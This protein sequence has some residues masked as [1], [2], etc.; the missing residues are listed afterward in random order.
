MTTIKNKTEGSA[1]ECIKSH[2]S[3]RKI[4]RNILKKVSAKLPHQL[5]AELKR[6][7]YGRQIKKGSFL[8]DEPEY[9]LL[10]GLIRSGDWVIDIGANIGHYT[11]R[12]SELVGATGRVIAFEPVPTTFSLLSANSQMF[13]HPNVTL[14]NTAVSNSLDVVGI[15][16]PQHFTGVSNYYRAHLSPAADSALSVL[17]MSLDSLYLDQPIACVKIDVEGHEAT[18]LAGMKKLIERSHPI[19]IVETGSD[20]VIND[21]TAMGYVA[22]RLNGSPNVLF[23]PSA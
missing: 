22:E 19:L 18:V 9:E 4:Y 23:R 1:Q 6:I 21:V 12:F 11:K 5:Q 2:E 8:T 15:S 16:I 20:K 14:V 10:H 3:R 17:T 7:Y 13:S